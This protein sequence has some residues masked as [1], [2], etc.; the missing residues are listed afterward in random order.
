VA[1]GSGVSQEPI[2]EEGSMPNPVS[3]ADQMDREDLEHAVP[4]S[5]TSPERPQVPHDP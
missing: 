2:Q 1:P 4:T 3:K 5:A